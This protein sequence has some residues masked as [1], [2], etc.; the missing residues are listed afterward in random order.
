MN[1]VAVLRKQIQYYSYVLGAIILLMFGRMIGNN[2][3]AYLA[4]AMETVGLF[5]VL[6]GDDTAEVFG[7]MLRFRR[8]RKQYNDALVVKKRIMILQFSL[9]LVCFG[10]VFLLADVIAIKLF[11][12]PNTALIIRILAPVL[13]L[14]MMSTLLIGYFQGSGAQMPAVFSSVL[15][16]I[17]FLIL[18]KLFCGGFLEYGEKVSALLK[19]D[20]FYGMYGAV[21]LALAIVL[22]EVVIL[23]AMVIFYFISD[24]NY[25]KK[26]CESGLHKAERLQ[27][28]LQGFYGLGAAGI[29]F[30]FLK[31]IFVLVA[32]IL[33]VSLEEIGL[34][35]GKYLLL[36]AIPVLF[37]VARYYIL[38]A[39]MISAMKNKNGRQVREKIQIGLQYAWCAGILMVVL[40]AVLAPQIVNAYFPEDAVLL[41]MLQGG[42]LLILAVILLAYLVVVHSAHKRKLASLL[43]LA[44]AAV[45]SMV[46]AVLLG[47]KMESQ[48]MAVIYAGVISLYLAVMI[49]GA[50]TISQYHLKLEYVQ[51]FILPLVCVGVVGV[52]VLLMSKLLAP[53]IGNGLTCWLGIVLG[54]VLYLVALG[55]C[56]VF[57][58]NEIEQLYGNV[59]KRILSVIFK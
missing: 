59:G 33:L 39:R 45:F 24:R 31:R 34:Y 57:S 16:Q 43:T 25:D 8:K 1:Q 58:E 23:I 6:L 13:F 4:I 36:C 42:S 40:M 30:S 19:N 54:V 47:G 51:V 46:L 48:L 55:F 32:L 22:S 11:Q 49:L 20:D 29:G 21:G 9:G 26:R 38:Y 2:G 27:D 18:G 5:M 12:I 41:N 7:K 56:R 14:R 53:H 37:V 17:L 15:R 52:I 50:I 44:G 28:T 10:A 35:Y 3:V